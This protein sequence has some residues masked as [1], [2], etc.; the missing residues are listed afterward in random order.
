[1]HPLYPKEPRGKLRFVLGFFNAQKLLS[2]LEAT[3]LLTV[4]CVPSQLF[5]GKNNKINIKGQKGS[6]VCEGGIGLFRQAFVIKRLRKK[7]R[8]KRCQVLS[9]R[10]QEGD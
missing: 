4:A 9:S 2:V 7:I 8:G 1:L 3:I 10:C 5:S 6:L